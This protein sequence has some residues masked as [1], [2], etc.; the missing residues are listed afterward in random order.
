M[1]KCGNYITLMYGL[2]HTI[3]TAFHFLMVKMSTGSGMFITTITP[4]YENEDLHA[5][6]LTIL[7]QWNPLW[8]PK[9]TMTDKSAV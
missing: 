2:Y 3:N 6:T 8:S 7:K 1:N 9:F 4:Q 5:K